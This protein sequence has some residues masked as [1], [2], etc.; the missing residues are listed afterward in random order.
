V[1][2]AHQ[3]A[4]RRR[5]R[6]TAPQR[7]NLGVSVAEIRPAATHVPVAQVHRDSGSGSV[8]A[9]VLAALAATLGF[10]ALRRLVPRN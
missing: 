5:A 2:R 8:G 3:E 10:F 4:R 7:A 9:A 1:K 6:R